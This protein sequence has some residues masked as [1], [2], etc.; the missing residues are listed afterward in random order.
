MNK[1]YKNFNKYYNPIIT[2]LVLNVTD[3]REVF[4]SVRKIFVAVAGHSAAG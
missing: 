4:R 1:Q 2:R 3:T